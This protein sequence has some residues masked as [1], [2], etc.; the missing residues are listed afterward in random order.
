MTT[1]GIIGSGNIGSTV[2][3]LA[4]DAGIDVV[5]SNSRGPDTLTELVAGLGEHA[6]AGTS[7][8]A[9]EAGDLVVVTVPLH[10]IGDLPADQLV[11][12]VVLDTCNY[13]PERDGQ[14]SALDDETTTTSEM[15]AERLPGAGVV[16]VFN[17]IYFEHLRV[18]ARPSGSGERAVLALAGS[19]ADAKERATEL[20]DRLGYD[21][22]D[23]GVLSEGWRFQRDTAAYGV[24]YDGSTDGQWSA[25]T[26][27]PA[28]A[29]ELQ[30]ALDDAQRYRDMDEGT[31]G[32][33]EQDA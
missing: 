30:S 26:A 3:R 17:N 25:E 19:D 16:K 4:V 18:L 15:V 21:A 10:A 14:I 6:R 32:A 31:A 7:A 12:K 27:K 2:A 13:Y 23:A 8:E 20:L 22:L 1:L 9:A 28:T 29:D 33:T 5:L 24:P 11:G